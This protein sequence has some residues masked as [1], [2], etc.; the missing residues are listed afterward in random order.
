L[1]EYAEIRAELRRVASAASAQAIPEGAWRL[2][3]PAGTNW[4]RKWRGTMRIPRFAFA[5][6][7][8]ALLILSTG[9]FLT[10]AKEAP[11]WFQWEVQGRDGKT[12]VSGAVPPRA[13][14]NP[15]YEVDCGMKYPEGMV[16]FR[17]RWLE[18][19][20]ETE[21]LGV[22]AVWAPRADHSGGGSQSV[23]DMPEREFLYSPGQELKIPVDGYGNLEIRGR[24]ES[25]LPKIVQAGLYPEYGKFRIDPPVLLVRGKE[26]LGRFD[27]GGGELSLGKSYF[28]YGQQGEGWY[29]FSAKPIEGAVEGTLT[30]NEVQFQ[31]DGK[32]YSLFTGN[33]IVFGRTRVWVKHYASIKNADPTSPGENW[34]AE[35]PALA[36]GGLENLAAN[37]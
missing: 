17:V 4:V 5:L 26:L 13:E 12:I 25:T 3:A 15:Y 32:Q 27:G 11:R 16:W 33:P 1:N 28:A 6:M 36:F 22:R 31:L 18:R 19:I 7:V 30:M 37:K 10:R 21:R 9:L 29:L 8:F 34:S 20:G 24:F 23:D 14:G 2:A 35:N